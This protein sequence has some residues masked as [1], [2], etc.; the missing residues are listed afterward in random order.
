[1]KQFIIPILKY[2]TQKQPLNEIAKYFNISILELINCIAIIN[3]N[4]NNQ[5]I[6]YSNIKCVYLT[7][8]IDWIDIAKLKHQLDKNYKIEVINPISSTNDYIKENLQNNKNNYLLISEYQTNG[9]GR[10]TNKS[11]YS[12]IAHDLTFSYLKEID[13]NI[14]YS[15]IPLLAAISIIK[16]NIFF[17]IKY[18]IKWP[19]DILD[20]NLQKIAG[21]LVECINK[22]NKKYIVIGIGINN[23]NNLNRTDLIA[24]IINEFDSTLEEFKKFGF[25]NLHQILLKNCIHINKKISLYNDNEIILEGINTNID[26][27]GNLEVLTTDNQIKYFNSS[28]ISLRIL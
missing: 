7:K 22:N 26:K 12:K 21:I 9:R 25:T 18:Y 27:K 28:Q 23:N 4:N 15:L 20:S 1:M 2:L 19:N 6:D 14:N 17:G 8:E 10:N 3:N 16:A 13:H 5:L 11:W 24:R